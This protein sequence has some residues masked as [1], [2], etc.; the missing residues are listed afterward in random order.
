MNIFDSFCIS[1]HLPSLSIGLLQA[2]FRQPIAYLEINCA[3]SAFGSELSEAEVHVGGVAGIGGES[4]ESGGSHAAHVHGARAISRARLDQIV[5]RSCM[6]LLCCD[7][8]DAI[9]KCA[10]VVWQ[11]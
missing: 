1:S 9:M 11:A 6:S 3:T 4:E 8:A 10:H 7:L 2:P 5:A